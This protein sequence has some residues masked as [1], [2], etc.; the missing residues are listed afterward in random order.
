MKIKG[1]FYDQFH[2]Q[3]NFSYM[4]IIDIKFLTGFHQ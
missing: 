2:A 4:T 3:L 1:S